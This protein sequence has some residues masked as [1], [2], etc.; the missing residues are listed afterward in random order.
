MVLMHMKGEPKTMQDDPTYDDVV[1]EVRGFLGERIEAAVS[2]GIEREQLCVDP[3]IGFGKTLE[4]NLDA[5][6]RHPR[7]PSPARPVAGGPS[8]ASGS[9]GR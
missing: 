8:A 4:H 9:S 3:G 5:P 2:A 1:A 7:V 6:A